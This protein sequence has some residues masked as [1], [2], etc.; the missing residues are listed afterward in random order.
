MTPV[1]FTIR[2]NE[3]RLFDITT[4]D[5]IYYKENKYNVPFAAI[6][7]ECNSISYWCKQTAGEESKQALFLF[8]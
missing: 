4:T 5:K 8:E 7:S 2:K 6:V 1:I 3:D